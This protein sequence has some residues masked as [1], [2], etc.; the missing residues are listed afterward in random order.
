MLLQIFW[1]RNLTMRF[2]KPGKKK[3][4]SREK[5]TKTFERRSFFRFQII[6]P[7]VSRFLLL[8]GFAPLF[9]GGRKTSFLV[10][11]SISLAF[12]SEDLHEAQH[13]ETRSLEAA[14]RN[15]YK[16]GKESYFTL[17]VCW[18][19]VFLFFFLGCTRVSMEVSN[20][21]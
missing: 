17:H 6:C 9:F 18:H 14:F 4:D 15:S 5:N 1:L 2:E 16:C 10:L 3:S 8:S 12:C 19:L 11:Y 20:N 13:E 7:V 21:R